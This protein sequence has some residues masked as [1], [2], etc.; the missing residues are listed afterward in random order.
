MLNY[1]GVKRNVAKLRKNNE[2][3]AK[4]AMS[5]S[6]VKEFT[7]DNDATYFSSSKECA[8]YSYK[9]EKQMSALGDLDA[10]VQEQTQSLQRLRAKMLGQGQHARVISIISKT[11]KD[12]GLTLAVMKPLP[13]PKATQT[14]GEE[15][16]RE[17]LFLVEAESGYKQLGRFIDRLRSAELMLHVHELRLRSMNRETGTLRAEVII[18]AFKEHEVKGEDV[19]P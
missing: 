13:P 2:C 18:A 19:R 11:A 8:E 12:E 14:E 9:K 15:G 16:V 10:A 5:K 4:E 3:S 6:E 1:L 17:S 7:Y